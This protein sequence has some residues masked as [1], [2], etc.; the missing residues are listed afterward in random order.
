MKKL[1]V[2]LVGLAVALALA[3]NAVAKLVVTGG[4]KAI[5]GLRMTI[6]DMD[7][8]LLSTT[9]GI[10][11]LQLF[12]PAGFHE[13]VMVD[14]PEIYVDY[15]LGPLLKGR[16]HLEEV[17]LKLRQ[18]TVVKNERGELNLNALRVVKAAKE[19]AAPATKKPQ[20]AR[21]LPQM[22]IDVLELHIGTVVYKDYST[23]TPQVMEFTVEVHERF[24]NITNP[25]ALA[26]VIISRA[27]A[28]TTLAN[29]MS[30]D[31]GALQSQLTTLV[32]ESLRK[33]VGEVAPGAL[34]SAEQAIQE[35]TGALKK[36]LG[37]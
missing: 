1:V 37:Q 16:A 25:Y 11:G 10:D 34:D 36:L 7:V 29:L 15:K 8:G 3:K 24:R 28:K 33:T 9:L 5:T 14:L 31:L 17:R 26:G 4:V 21:G 19:Q 12:N 6:R 32:S 18:L 30:L 2:V 22:Q 20:A 23:P 27:L 13:P 35:T